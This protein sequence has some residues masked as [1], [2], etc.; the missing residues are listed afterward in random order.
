MLFRF[1]DKIFGLSSTWYNSTLFRQ[2]RYLWRI[3]PVCLY[4]DIALV[5]FIKM[6]EPLILCLS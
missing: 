6:A 1:Y 3:P 4:L 2:V 5:Q